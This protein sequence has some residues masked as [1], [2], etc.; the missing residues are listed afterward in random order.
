MWVASY[1]VMPHAYRLATGPGEARTSSPVAGSCSR[2]AGPF[3]GRTGTSARR[4][5]SMSVRLSRTSGLAIHTFA[6]G[7]VAWLGG[8]GGLADGG[9][10]GGGVGGGGGLVGGQGEGWGGG[11]GVWLARRHRPGR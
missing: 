9:G 6:P 1:G 5:D 4:H 8:G 10:E 7:R 2:G 3:P 11:E